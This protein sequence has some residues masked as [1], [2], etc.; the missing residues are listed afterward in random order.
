[1]GERSPSTT[2]EVGSGGAEEREQTEQAQIGSWGGSGGG[3]C[4]FFPSRGS[5][6]CTNCPSVPAWER[7]YK[8][9]LEPSPL[10]MC[11]DAPFISEQGVSGEESSPCQPPGDKLLPAARGGSALTTAPC[12]R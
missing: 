1:M 4:C 8:G 7:P 5:V 12:R 2:T 9:N 10:F 11:A 3:G 6:I